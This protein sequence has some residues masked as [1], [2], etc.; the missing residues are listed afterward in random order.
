MTPVHSHPLSTST[1][2]PPYDILTA[3]QPSSLLALRA[4]DLRPN[5]V[6]GTEYQLCILVYKVV[7]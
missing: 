7:L 6:S 3:G 5:T 1:H 4:E 2:S